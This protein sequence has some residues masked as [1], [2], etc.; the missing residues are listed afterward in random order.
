MPAR[1]ESTVGAYRVNIVESLFSSMLSSR[2]NEIVQKPDAPFLGAGAGRTSVVRTAEA[3]S[4]VA[5]VRDGG[6]EP[7]LEALFVETERVARFG[8]TA[9]ELARQK[10]IV[11]RSL[12][13]AVA[14]RDNQQSADLA[15]EY[16]RNYLEGEP[17]PGIAYEQAL[18]DRFLPGITLDEINAL[19]RTWAPASSRWSW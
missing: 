9:A 12:E 17:I 8:F 7:G 4:L 18:Y 14:E 13:R 3:L 2:F 6:V 19:A 5:T 10:V 1:D 16:S 15:A 11:A